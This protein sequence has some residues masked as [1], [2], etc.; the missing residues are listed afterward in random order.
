MNQKSH[1]Q[2]A[3]EEKLAKYI[4]KFTRYA[5]F[6]HLSQERREIL[7]GT[8]LYLIEEQDLV[9]DDVPHIGYLDDLMV[10]VTAASSFIDGEKG[11]DIPGVITREEV[12]ADDA[13]VKQHEG[14]LYGTH[15]TSLKA[16]QKMGSGKSSDLPA[17]CTR[18]KEKY[19][20]L[21]RMES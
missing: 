19:A 2:K 6:S 16:L 9:P 14:L 1:L 13:F 11:Q 18:I 3:V 8:L 21:G 10:F 4:N 17:L 12:E 7:T 5:A 20:T 15:K